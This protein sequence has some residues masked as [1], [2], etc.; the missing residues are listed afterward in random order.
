MKAEEI[1]EY[2]FEELEKVSVQLNE[3]MADEDLNE[4]RLNEASEGL[5]PNT[6]DILNKFLNEYYRDECTQCNGE[7]TVN[8]GYKLIS[9]PACGGYGYTIRKLKEGE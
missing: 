2:F 3:L 7:G 6:C 9:C 1:K 4:D 8:L 5:L